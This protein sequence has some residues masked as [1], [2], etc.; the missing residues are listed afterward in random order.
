MTKATAI[1]YAGDG[2]RANSVHPG[3]I[4]TDMLA[5]AFSDP[6]LRENR[7]SKI[8]LRRVGRA[9]AVAYGVLFPASDESSYMTG[10]ELVID[11]GSTAQ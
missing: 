6:V 10:N 3:P 8:P 2:I 1:Q 4:E 7:V 9:E 11:G 5:E